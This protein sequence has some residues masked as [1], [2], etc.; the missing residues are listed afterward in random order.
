MEQTWGASPGLKVLNVV[1]AV[2]L[3]LDRDVTVARLEALDHSACRLVDTMGE[4]VPAPCKQGHLR[5]RARVQG[6]RELQ[7]LVGDG[8][9]T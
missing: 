6:Q 9:H 3:A 8:G 1:G 5:R 7:L 2:K 4:K